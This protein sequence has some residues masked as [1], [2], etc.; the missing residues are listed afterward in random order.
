MVRYV[1][2]KAGASEKMT[3][4]GLASSI[5]ARVVGVVSSLPYLPYLPYP[6]FHSLPYLT[7]YKVT[8][9]IDNM[10]L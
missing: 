9:T 10:S 4:K 6:T 8:T 3:Y 5:S 2:S 7:E 1:F